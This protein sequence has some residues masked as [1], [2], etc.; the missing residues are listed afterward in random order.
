MDLFKHIQLPFANVL[1]YHTKEY[2]SNFSGEILHVQNIPIPDADMQL[3]NSY[4]ESKGVSKLKN[5]L[6]F[7]RK[8]EYID[9][10][11][12]HVDTNSR[13]YIRCS[14]VIPVSGCKHTKQYWYS[15]DYSVE[16]RTTPSGSDY[17]AIT[18]NKMPDFAGE[19]E[20]YNNPTLVRTDVP[21]S[22]YS[23]NNEY[24][25][26]CTIRFINNESF[27]YLSEKLST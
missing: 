8:M 7:K 27:E 20:I 19:V 1:Q 10:T 25:I 12:C 16:K 22:A 18:W 4:L 26:T 2:M 23:F 24:R 6:A 5:V 14:V 11:D 13:E 21:H 15:G 17:Y 9:Y 3:I